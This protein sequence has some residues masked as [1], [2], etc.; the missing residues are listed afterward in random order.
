MHKN[1]IDENHCPAKNYVKG[2]FPR[3][4][5]TA[6]Q[7]NLLTQMFWYDFDKSFINN[8]EKMLMT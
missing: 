5:T 1:G 4:E 7:A 6:Q 3:H 2:Q 8:F